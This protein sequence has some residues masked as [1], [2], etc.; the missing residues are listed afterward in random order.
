VTFEDAGVVDEDVYCTHLLHH[1][2]HEI[3]GGSGVSDVGPEEHVRLTRQGGEGLAR[4]FLVSLEVN[5]DARPV[6]GELA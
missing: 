6:F 4:G 1:G 2:V 3:P 5:G